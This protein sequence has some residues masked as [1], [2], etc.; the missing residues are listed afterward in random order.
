M[1]CWSISNAAVELDPTGNRKLSKLPSRGRIDPLIASVMTI[2][3]SAREPQ[4]WE[5]TTK[6]ALAIVNRLRNAALANIEG[7]ERARRANGILDFAVSA[8]SS[9]RGYDRCR[10]RSSARRRRP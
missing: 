8:S 4:E 1:L 3:Q 5:C 9:R 7:D 6:A 10:A 2:G